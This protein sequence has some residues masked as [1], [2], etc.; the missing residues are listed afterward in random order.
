LT[1][2][3]EAHNDQ[4]RLVFFPPNANICMDSTSVPLRDPLA[5]YLKGSSYWSAEEAGSS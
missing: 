5:V 1:G 2:A 4:F 3:I